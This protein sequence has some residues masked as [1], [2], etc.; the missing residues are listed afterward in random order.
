MCQLPPYVHTKPVTLVKSHLGRVGAI[1]TG[2]STRNHIT[3]SGTE[4]RFYKS[5]KHE[6]KYYTRRIDDFLLRR[7]DDFLKFRK[8]VLNIID[9]GK[10]KR[11]R[12]IRDSLDS[13]LE[14]NRKMA[15]LPS[16]DDL[17]SSNS[18]KPSGGG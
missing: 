15:S 17:A 14:E 9:W 5:W 13:L 12:E 10:D 8:D 2:T 16:S 1:G 3:M 6:L 18:D 4:A 7:P 11:L